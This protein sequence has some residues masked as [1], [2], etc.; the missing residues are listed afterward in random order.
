VARSGSRNHPL[1]DQQAGAFATLKEQR[2]KISKGGSVIAAG[3][4]FDAALWT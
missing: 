4:E 1:A 3:Q 2:A